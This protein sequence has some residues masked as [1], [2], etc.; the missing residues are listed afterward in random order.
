MAYTL[1]VI[2][3]LTLIVMGVVVVAYATFGGHDHAAIAGLNVPAVHCQEDEVIGWT[4][5]DT[6]GC[7][8]YEEVN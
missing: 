5:V 4:G 7:I 3:V 1:L 8:N 2:A 6:L